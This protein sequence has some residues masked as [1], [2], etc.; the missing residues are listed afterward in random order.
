MNKNPI[1]RISVLC[2]LILAVSP[3]WFTACVTQKTDSAPS[4][5]SLTLD[6]AI[7][8]TASYFIQ[9]IP[10][11]AKIALIPFDAPTGRLSDYVFEELWKRFED[12]KNFVMVDR[13]N[14]DRIEAEIKIQYESGN[15]DD[16]A[17]VSMSK[18]YGAEFLV[19]GQ[20]IALGKDA[21]SAEYRITVYATDVEKASSSQRAYVVRQDSRLASLI[22][23][24]IDEEVERAVSIMAKSVSQ[25]TVIAIGRISYANTQTVTNLSA[26]LKNGIISGAQKQ[27][28]KFQIATDSESADFAVSSR[29]LTVETP[30]ANT[31]VQ[32]VVTGSY[33]PL[34]SGAEVLLQLISTSGN[35]AVLSSAKFFI[36][37]SEM[38]RRKL[39][40]LPEKDTAII[41]K[42]EY[43]AKQK[44]VDP[45]AG[46]NN[47]WAFTA[48]PDVL[49]GI[50]RDGDYMTMR[51]YSARD[52]YFRIIHI[53]VNGATQVIYPVSVSDNNFIRAGQTRRIPDNTRYKMGAPFG[54]EIILVAA[55]DRPFTSVQQSGTLSADNIARGL[56]VESDNKTVMS[57]SATAK[58]SYTILPK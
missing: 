45:Y 39:S 56:T 4:S 25:K 53:D 48:T 33:S 15:V 31:S 43:E 18:Q 9:K 57:P 11:K 44:A 52:C 36:P 6:A 30:V 40:L 34:D 14:L 29:G 22:N 27:R 10:A 38:E 20:I 50:Y 55:Y 28:D 8:E 5:D 54:E 2:L 1:L 24:S 32:A 51:V 26:W 58:F 23:V 13:K 49:D 47:K 46:K 35:K 16:N 21:S 3:L 7:T 19:Y 41:S 42:A 12:S 37:S 17:I